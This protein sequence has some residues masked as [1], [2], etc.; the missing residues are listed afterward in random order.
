MA[1]E[2]VVAFEFSMT[3]FELP[4]PLSFSPEIRSIGQRF[5]TK[6]PIIWWK[7]YLIF[8]KMKDKCDW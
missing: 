7:G 5:V 8:T 2:H 4:H 6:K 3:S 1:V